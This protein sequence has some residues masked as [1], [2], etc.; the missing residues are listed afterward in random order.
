MANFV[1][2]HG[3]DNKYD[4]SNDLA[5]DLARYHGL[6]TNRRI[7]V[8]GSCSYHWVGEIKESLIFFT[9]DSWQ[10]RSILK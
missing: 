10:N 9:S 4:P 1:C 6:I 7:P 8:D 5:G 3:T 2:F